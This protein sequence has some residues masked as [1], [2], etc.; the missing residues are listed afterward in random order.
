MGTC[1]MKKILVIG[2]PGAG[3]STFSR[4]LSAKTHIPLHYLDIIW[5]RPDKT[6]IGREAFVTEL[7]RIMRGDEWII[8]GTYLHTLSMRLECCDTVILFD[9][10]A[11]ICLEGA[12]HRT[13]NPREDMP[14]TQSELDSDFSQVIMDFPKTQMPVINGLLSSS[15]RNLNIIRFTSREDADAFIDSLG[16][17]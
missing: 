10:P 5:H 6:T 15:N 9:I 11:E 3:K 13:G 4:K 8:D 12:L 7:A 2:C 1:S 17:M 16:S 14:W